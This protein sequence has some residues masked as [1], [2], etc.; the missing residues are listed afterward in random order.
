M[1]LTTGTQPQTS[2]SAPPGQPAMDYASLR[3]E[4]ISQLQRLASGQWTDF[5]DHDPGITILEQFCYALTDLGYR[6]DYDL[7]DL[8][9]SGSPWPYRFLYTPAEILT[10]NPVNV[11]DLRKLVIDVDG[12]KNAWI[13]PVNNPTPAVFYDPS[14]QSLYLDNAPQRTLVS[15]R[16]IYQVLIESD[17][18]IS[19][20]EI[21]RAV[22][23]RLH[24]HR[25]LCED[26]N[27]PKILDKQK[28]TV[29]ARIEIGRVDDASRLL[30]EIYHALASAIS[31][32]IHFYS[33][34]DRLA[35]GMSIDEIMDGPVLQSGF[36]DTDELEASASK[37]A[38]R[39]S[40]LIHVI[41]TVDGVRAVNDIS[42][43]DGTRTEAWYLT[44][45]PT[46]TPVLVID[47]IQLE[48]NGVPVR[49]DADQVRKFFD[50]LQ[51]A[52]RPAA[53]PKSERDI[54]LPVG[55]DR[56]VGN[57]YSL[58]HQ[59]PATYGIGALGLPAPAEPQRKA[60]A[61]QLKAY[62]LF[63][64]QL[65]AN[66]FAQLAHVSDLFSFDPAQLTT[67]F[68]QPVDSIDDN[69]D[70]GL[71]PLWVNDPDTRKTNLQK[72]TANPSSSQGPAT[73]DDRKNRFLNHLLAR[74]AE[75]FLAGA[76]PEQE[77]LIEAKCRFLQDHREL[78][79]DRGRACNAT[80][81]SWGTD[82][83]SGLEKRIS[84][85][86]GIFSSGWQ[87]LSGMVAGDEGGFHLVE[88]IL[89]R[90]GDA[91]TSP[92]AKGEGWQAGALATLS[93]APGGLLST[94]PYS[95]Q[96][97]VVFPDWITRFN[98]EGFHE[99]IRQTV[100]DETPAHIRIHL[101]WLSQQAM[102]AFEAAYK[103][104]PAAVPVAGDV[105]TSD[106]QAARIAG[107][108]ARDR[109][110]DLIG[111]GSPYPLRDLIVNYPPVV[112]Q[113]V[114]ADVTIVGGQTGVSYEL[115]D[116]DGNPLANVPLIAPVKVSDDSSQDVI[117]TT[118]PV[119]KDISYTILATRAADASGK[120]L[121]TPLESYLSQTVSIKMGI[122]AHLLPRFVPIPQKDQTLNSDVEIVINYG[123]PI[124]VFF[125]DG[126][127][128]QA[129]ISYQLVLVA[130]QKE[131]ILSNPV[132]GNPAKPIQLASSEGFNEDT[133]LRIK[134]YRTTDSTVWAYLDAT[135]SVKVRPNP[136]VAVSANPAIL[137]Y[138]KP[139][140]VTLADTQ[141]SVDYQLFTRQLVPADYGSPVTADPGTVVARITNRDGLALAGSFADAAG[142][143]SFTIA[144]VAEDTLLVV[145]AT[146]KDNGETLTLTQA[147]VVLVR[148]N[149]APVVGVLQSPVDANAIGAVTV[150][151]TQ[152]GVSYQLLLAGNTI[153]PPG[154]HYEDRGV[155][156]SR[157]QIDFIV[158]PPDD[159]AA[160]QALW[161]IL[162]LPTGP[163]T[164][165]A[166]FH[167]L[168]TKIYTGLTAELTGTA[169]INV[170]T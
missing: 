135:L 24:D 30:A 71:E 48:R 127:L 110:I 141:A 81:P 83:L 60:Q 90:P 68:S 43:S 85:K 152:K 124:W 37:T 31:P 129:G 78:S 8:L 34:A 12:V 106:A 38:L 162:N 163:I 120:A 62:L 13:E 47:Q 131:T 105:Q 72:I 40:D 144:S 159:S 6:I 69:R 126:P 77:R 65:L 94:D 41:M 118:P 115:R 167:I 53:L 133:Q 149:P 147:V 139:V 17:D 70:L 63:F 29:K 51:Q 35:Q 4:A 10:T 148:P 150:N 1:A 125:D 104:W 22:S 122:N 86:L 121:P 101:Q 142:Q 134:A 107:R 7:K 117:L 50:G 136:S 109:L 166:T 20:S 56:K 92:S 119:T 146:K 132:E 151:G 103:D 168:A 49:P 28:I 128:T 32:R 27:N 16:G 96:L 91:D 130:D 138:G 66:D 25:N 15:M 18:S 145:V 21:L 108:A 161:Q 112:A 111:L 97:T 26:F 88:H 5:N 3:Q 156:T 75:E 73:V 19:N 74:F 33:L 67:Y 116:E 55:R 143:Q 39:T 100:R 89:L 98:K 9:A 153:N 79:A 36:I 155:G 58:Q 102:S 154:Y 14:D 165:P 52:D 160:G 169:T 61:S 59:F 42:L 2:S 93:Q 113:N 158:G 64:D 170:K 44:L 137:D 84:R 11:T 87:E 95:M 99:F 157:I 45:N 123:D 76:L 164:A 140:T 82:N 46:F 54:R 23:Q 57:Y 80:L 114:S